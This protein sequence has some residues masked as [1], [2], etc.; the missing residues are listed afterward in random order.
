MELKLLNMNRETVRQIIREDLGM[1]KISEKMAPRILTDDLKQHQLHILSDILHTAEMA[2]R[3]NTGDETWRF[4]YD[5]ET[6]CQNMQWETQ[7]SPWLKRTHVSLTVQDHAWFFDHKG[8]VRYELIAQRQIVNQ[9]CYLE[10]LPRL[11]ESVQRKRPKLWPDKC[12]HHDNAP[13]HDILRVREFLAKKSVTKTDCPPLS[14]DLAPCYF[15]LLPKLKNA[16]KGQRSADFL[17]SNAM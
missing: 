13:A 3:V 14:P 15:W 2:D 6:K 10:V 12:I 9:Q 7:N 11:Q 17:T 1:R 5:L 4:Q 8:I 16:L